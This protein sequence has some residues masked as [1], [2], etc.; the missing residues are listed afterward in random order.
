MLNI[1]K[2]INIEV[3]LITPEMAKKYLEKNADNR[4]IRKTTVATY[5]NDMKNGRWELTHQGI[6]FND[7]GELVD[8]QHRLAAIVDSGVSIRMVI[9]N[10]VSSKVNLDNH[11]KRTLIDS[12][13]ASA[14]QIAISRIILDRIQG[15]PFER[16]ASASE[17]AEFIRDHK[18]NLDLAEH[19]ITQNK[20]GIRLSAVRAAIF[21]ASY[22]EPIERLMEFA[23]CIQ[24]GRYDNYEEDSAAMKFRDFLTANKYSTQKGHRSPKL[25]YLKTEF[26]IKNFCNRLETKRA[27]YKEEIT[28][29]VS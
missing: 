8:G 3:K 6:A 11:I 28:Y 16:K 29:A 4:K 2:D 19:S 20:V 27:M 5:A 21:A 25:V 12:T 15:N 26:A 24:S 23:D 22:H 18:T 9:A 17:I 10:G 14:I 7:Q 1:K 13:G